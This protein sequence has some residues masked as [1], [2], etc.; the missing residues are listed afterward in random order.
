VLIA[1][2]AAACGSGDAQDDPTSAD[3][4]AAP[5]PSPTAAETTAAEAAALA[6]GTND[7]LGAY[8]VDGAG[9][10]LYLFTSDG[11]NTSTCYDVCAVTWPPMLTDTGEVT[12]SGA[13]DAALIGTA[14]RTEGIL[15]VT[16]D[17]HPL[18][19]YADDEEPGE[20]DGQGVNDVWFAVNPDGTA[21]TKDE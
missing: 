3:T 21:N 5:S 6:T 17:G 18:Y 10:V 1:F 16:Y 20:T 11:E 15:Q 9:M 19:Y 4:S 12:A 13:V 2:A 8:L 7:E 14:E